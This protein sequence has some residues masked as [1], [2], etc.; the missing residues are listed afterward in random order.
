MTVPKL[1][2]GISALSHLLWGLHP[3]LSR[4]LQT[5]PTPP[6]DGLNLLA[7]GQ[8]LA[9]SINL[10][11]TAFAT[12]NQS[13]EGASSSTYHSAPLSGHAAPTEFPSQNIETGENPAETSP[14]LDFPDRQLAY[15]EE[16]GSN[17]PLSFRNEA[18]PSIK[19]IQSSSSRNSSSSS[20]S[21]STGSSSSKSAE[22]VSLL[23]RPATRL[24]LLF[25]CMAALRAGT[26][27]ESSRFTSAVNVQMVAMAGPLITALASS[28]LLREAVP[29]TLWPALLVAGSGEALVLAAQAGLVSSGHPSVD[30]SSGSGS[31]GSNSGS[32]SVGG[33]DNL[34]GRDVLGLGLQLA[35]LLFSGVARVVMK[36]S[37]KDFSASELMVFQ[38][39]CTALPALGWS[40]LGATA[41]GP[42]GTN[43]WEA[44]AQLT[45][46]GW[47]CFATLV[48]GVMV[49]AAT[50]QVRAV[51]FLGPAGHAS[52]QPIRLFATLAAAYFL[53]NERVTQPAEW[54]GLVIVLAALGWYVTV[55]RALGTKTSN[56]ASSNHD[57]GHS[58]NKG[59]E[60]ADGSREEGGSSSAGLFLG[61]LASP[62][63]N[64]LAG[65]LAPPPKHRRS[66]WWFQRLLWPRPNYR[67]GKSGGRFGAMSSNNSSS[68]RSKSSNSRRRSRKGEDVDDDDGIELLIDQ[69][70]KNATR[71]RAA[72]PASAT[73]TARRAQQRKT[74]AVARG[75]PAAVHMLRS[76]DDELADDS[77][78]DALLLGPVAQRATKPSKD[79]E[80]HHHHHRQGGGGG[81]D[82]WSSNFPVAN[83]QQA[84]E[85]D[86]DDRFSSRSSTKRSSRRSR[87]SRRSRSS[88]R[89]RSGSGSESKGRSSR[90]KGATGTKKGSSNKSTTR[91][92]EVSK[93]ESSRSRSRR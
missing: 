52:L 2:L 9:L 12:C 67:P 18:P 65:W 39:T 64:G 37:E 83:D 24:A 35:S 58:H 91:L 21:G 20:S 81:E 93:N 56:K 70:D 14:S 5:R 34:T 79:G 63:T 27:I 7:I 49:S 86:D 3:V 28:A 75:P 16:D 38:Y 50:L 42:T 74:R 85:H 62:A 23:Q 33:S 6:L 41:A 53:L 80:L 89:S 10:L 36:A 40:F 4:Y 48:L 77:E 51:R 92:S 32:S 68:S 46:T 8:C 87:R 88:S 78:E 69:K 55:G 13:S 30:S 43:V 57:S 15:D 76:D 11:S 45:L 66:R 71:A 29:W 84:E 60:L 90:H 19:N 26:N 59:S 72:T 61:V 25:G 82:R 47:S 22:C 17:E 1:E 31:S 44:W 73:M 54:V